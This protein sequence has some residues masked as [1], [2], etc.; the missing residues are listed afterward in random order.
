MRMKHRN[1]ATF[2]I[3]L[4][5]LQLFAP[6]QGLAL[7]GGNKAPEF[8]SFQ[9]FG[10]DNMV[11][12]ATGDFSYNIPLMNVGFH[13]INLFYQAG[14][15]MDQEA[16]M[17]GLGWNINSGMINRTM[18]GIPDDFKGD[19]IVKEMYT[20]PNVTVGLKTG[21]DLELAGSEMFKLGASV[22]VSVN[23]LDGI[24]FDWSISPSFSATKSNGL[25]LTA[26]LGLSSSTHGG[27]TLSPNVG[28]H[29]KST[30]KVKRERQTKFGIGTSINSRGGLKGLS[31]SSSLGLSEKKH[32][33]MSLTSASFSLAK[34]SF[35]PHIS[36]PTK[37]TAFA[38]NMSAGGA[39]FTVQAGFF[40]MG[41]FSKQEYETN[42]LTLPSYGLLYPS[43]NS[44]GLGLNDFHRSNDM[45]QTEDIPN[46]AVPQFDFDIYTVAGPGLSGSLQLKR[47][48]FG[49]CSDRRTISNSNDNTIG[50]EL[51]AGAYTHIG[52]DLTTI[53]S[54]NITQEWTS[55]NDLKN[56]FEFKDN[57]Y[58][59]NYENAFFRK[60]DEI[61]VEKTQSG[62]KFEKI[63]GKKLLKPDLTKVGGL[64]YKVNSSLKTLNNSSVGFYNLDVTEV[65]ER[66]KRKNNIQYRTF[67]EAKFNSFSKYVLYDNGNEDI[68]NGLLNQGIAKNHHVAEIIVDNEDGY[69]YYYGLPVYNIK[70]IEASF[71]VDESDVDEK[72]AYTKGLVEYD[73]SSDQINNGNGTDEFYTKTTIPP[74]VSSYLLTAIV[75]SD[76]QDL[77][78]NG[79]SPDD[80][81]DYVKFSYEKMDGVYKWRTPH[82]KKQ[83]VGS[84]NRGL[85]TDRGDDKANYVYGERQQ[86]FPKAIQNKSEI[87][88][89]EYYPTRL[90]ALPAQGYSGGVDSISVDKNRILKRITKFSLSD[91]MMKGIHAEPLKS[92]FFEYTYDLCKNVPNS[93]FGKGKLTLK[94]LYL[95][96]GRSNK[97]RLSPYVFDYGDITDTINNPLYEPK[98]VNRWG[99]YQPLNV[100]KNWNTVPSHHKYLG[101][102]LTT[103]FPYVP[104]NQRD[105]QDQF[106]AAWNLKS[107]QLPSGGKIQVEYEADDYAFVQDKRAMQMMEIAFT[108]DANNLHSDGRLYQGS[109]KF[110]H[111]YFEIKDQDILAR[112]AGDDSPQDK[113]ILKSEYIGDIEHKLLYYKVF[114]NFFYG[115]ERHEYVPGWTRIVDYG[116]KTHNNQVY[117]YVKVK[118]AC[119]K[120]R[121]ISNCNQ[122]KLI[123]PISKS[124]M[125]AIRLNYADAVWGAPN[126]T[127]DSDPNNA[128]AAIM[129]LASTLTQIPTFV[130]GPN[131]KMK[132]DNFGSKIMIGKSF[133]RL[134]NPN[135]KKVSGSHRVKSIVMSDN[136]DLMTDSGFKGVFGKKYEYSE[137][138]TINGVEREVSTG[139]AAYEPVVGGEEN[140]LRKGIAFKEELLLAPDN[141]KYQEEPLLEDYYPSPQ[142]K[143][144]KVTVR[145]LYSPSQKIDDLE[146]Y[147][148]TGYQEN[149]F[150]T[151]RDFP[152]K[153][154]ASGTEPKL[155]NTPKVFKFLKINYEEHL[156]NGQGYLFVDP[157]MHGIPKANYVYN[158][159]AQLISGQEFD[160]QQDSKGD[161]DFNVDA[162]HQDGIVHPSRMG[163]DYN[164]FIDSR[165]ARST[166]ITT[167]A[168][169]NTEGFPIAFVPGI[170]ITILPKFA[171]EV[172]QFR[173]LVVVK[174]IRQN[175][176]LKSTTSINGPARIKTE[177]LV[178]DAETGNPIVTRTFNEFEDPIYQASLPS[179]LHYGRMGQSYQNSDAQ[180]EN[181]SC[182]NGVV[183]FSAGS[184]LDRGLTIGDKL[185]YLDGGSSKFAW[186]LNKTVSQAYLIDEVGS[187][188]NFSNKNLK[189]YESGYNNKASMPI[190]QYTTLNEN[191]V[192]TI[193]GEKKIIIEDGV[194]DAQATTYSESWQTYCSNIEVSDSASCTCVQHPQNRN[195]LN[196]LFS[197]IEEFGHEQGSGPIPANQQPYGFDNLYE[198]YPECPVS[199]F[200]Y[201]MQNNGCTLSFNQSVAKC[202]CNIEIQ[203]SPCLT[204]DPI[205]NITFTPS[206]LK[207]KDCDPSNLYIDSAYVSTNGSRTSTSISILTDCMNFGRCQ[208]NIVASTSICDIGPGYLANPFIHNLRGQWRPHQSF[209]FQTDRRG[210]GDIR[211]DGTYIQDNSNY[212]NPFINIWD[213]N[214][215]IQN[216]GRW[217]W[218]NETTIINPNG[219][220]LEAVD[221]LG[222]HSAEVPGYNQQ[223]IIAVA[224]NAKLNEIAYSGYEQRIVNGIDVLANE[225]F[226]NQ[227]I[228]NP[229]NGQLSLNTGSKPMELSCKSDIHFPFVDGTMHNYQLTDPN[230]GNL[231]LRLNDNST[232]IHEFEIQERDCNGPQGYSFAP[233]IVEE[234][235]CIPK[236]SPSPDK[237]YLISGWLKDAR[238]NGSDDDGSYISVDIDGQIQE[239]K[240]YGPLIDG[241]RKI[242]GTFEVPTNAS[243]GKIIVSNSTRGCYIDD[244]RVHPFH[245]SM[246]T[247][248]YDQ[249]TLR[250]TFEHDDNNYFT[251]YDYGLDGK[252]KRISKQTE[253]GVQTLQ[254]ST[255]GQQ[256]KIN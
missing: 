151:Y 169:G 149:H 26:G 57:R 6:I 222:R 109:D 189:V 223:K 148:N 135:K 69:R 186:V 73:G 121:K 132:N 61:L 105:L 166:T 253:R 29:I 155:A 200:T 89:Y 65:S 207:I 216:M 22:G 84:I 75:S 158:S 235:D 90:D 93:E 162:L 243:L 104:Q 246:K 179:Y 220:E 91:Y 224:A 205:T 17:V 114:G 74:Y 122:N 112:L 131:F 159:A 210:A 103:D 248:N 9:P 230:S 181:V 232:L 123:N 70:Q 128:E 139:V 2:L 182:Q 227:F 13:G 19:E 185:W 156:T 237:K 241:W 85:L 110:Y 66:L 80:Y 136:W 142:I 48:D 229:S 34:P 113:N 226:Y 203:F 130:T 76:Y 209:V 147:D 81:G 42:S 67:E 106:A 250:F 137:I 71:A 97:G 211:T 127:P 98:A 28:F 37:N 168:T 4:M 102:L 11:D 152:I 175:G 221:P 3:G 18:R 174:T 79:P 56:P 100:K 255:F 24:G 218:T 138:E 196:F 238:L 99:G 27:V 5:V 233:Y 228:Y 78:G 72:L 12:P 101:D 46:L 190:G 141:T 64:D 192:K 157:Q 58:K 108:G 160:Y 231:S 184:D 217:T 204:S 193:G 176:I 197:T 178:W 25:G 194:L 134:Y 41:Y 96:N 16:T 55:D 62:D 177:N 88:L 20:K 107:I 30:K 188:I 14:V 236:F 115:G 183:S 202:M 161:L 195:F 245:A 244:L 143:Y 94:K 172:K 39:V 206:A 154:K 21:L 213:E 49:I 170:L 249:E 40:G 198:H 36:F 199:S 256:K 129:A 214:Y 1:K 31:M 212:N 124:I 191:P 153:A 83:N 215:L 45:P 125:Q 234:C 126:E 240:S 187:P 208:R 120:D 254:E 52:A 225:S 173:S 44:D 95:L 60:A 165:E 116:T 242:E 15:T 201:Q 117:G 167:G 92:T 252:L 54:T 7:S 140:T 163:I 86:Y 180:F 10:L 63:G 171:R 32:V 118:P 239:I 23:S 33:R 219:V 35:I 47:G 38:F 111:L 251:K 146:I 68:F 164:I 50:V 59:L 247:Y 150:Y 53:S 43:F 145:D 77:T 51:G 87:A 144:S 8:E 119:I 82:T 133:I